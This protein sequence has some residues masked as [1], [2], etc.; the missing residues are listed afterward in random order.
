MRPQP[1]WVGG[2]GTELERGDSAF[3]DIPPY[4]I[5]KESEGTSGTAVASLLLLLLVIVL[6]MAYR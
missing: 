3:G 4:T 1:E 2:E 5:T 6:Y